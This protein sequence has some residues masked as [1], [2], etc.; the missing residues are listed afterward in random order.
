MIASCCCDDE[1][2]LD[3]VQKNLL[4]FGGWRSFNILSRQARE[5]RVEARQRLPC[6]CPEVVSAGK[7]WM[8]PASLHPTD[9]PSYAAHRLVRCR[10]SQ[11]IS[12]LYEPQLVPRLSRMSRVV[13]ESK[14]VSG[15]DYPGS[16]SGPSEDIRRRTYAISILLT[17]FSP[18][19]PSAT[20]KA[21]VQSS[22]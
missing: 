14:V 18:L 15:A 13:T 16:A 10:G 4:D 1:T 19:L 20:P 7:D 6:S 3:I 5:R 2:D 17:D 12:C 11:V 9:Q 22:I 21:R 8:T